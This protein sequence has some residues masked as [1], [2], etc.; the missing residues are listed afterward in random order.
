MNNI[1]VR[2]KLTI[3]MIVSVLALAICTYLSIVNMNQLQTKALDVIEEDVRSSYD[4]EIR[5][6]VENVISLCQNIYDKYQAGEYTEQEAKKLA[7][8]EIRA[9][10]YGDNGYFWVDV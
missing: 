7:A 1:K 5:H 3:V 8:D 4:E 10:R 2:A 9:L 6:Q